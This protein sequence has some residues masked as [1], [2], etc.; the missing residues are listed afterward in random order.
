MTPL[1]EF[2]DK[3]QPESKHSSYLNRYLH[4]FLDVMLGKTQ[5]EFIA[6]G[7]KFCN[8]YSSDNRLAIEARFE[9][10][11]S[12]T[13]D[14]TASS[15]K[16][17]D[18]LTSDQVNIRYQFQSSK[19]KDDRLIS[20]LGKP[21]L[22]QTFVSK[23]ANNFTATI[24]PPIQANRNT[25]ETVHGLGGFQGLKEKNF[26]VCGG[27]RRGWKFLEEW[28]S[29]TKTV[30]VHI[31]LDFT[32]S[33]NGPR[34]E[35]EYSKRACYRINK[36]RNE[37]HL[38]NT[39]TK[40]TQTQ[41]DKMHVNTN[42]AFLNGFKKRTP[43]LLLNYHSPSNG[44]EIL[45]PDC[46]NRQ[47]EYQPS[48][49]PQIARVRCLVVGVDPLKPRTNDFTSVGIETFTI[50]L[51]SSEKRATIR[52]Y[53]RKPEGA[54]LPDAW[55]SICAIPRYG[56]DDLFRVPV[57]ISCS[58]ANDI[59]VAVSFLSNKIKKSFSCT[60]LSVP[61]CH[62]TRKNYEG[63]DTA[64]FPKPRQGNSRGRFWIRTTDLPQL[65]FD[66]AVGSNSEA[67]DCAAPGRLVFQLLRYSR[68]RDARKDVI[69]YCAYLMS[70]K[71]GK[72]GLGLSKNFQQPQECQVRANCAEKSD[73]RKSL[74]C[75]L[76]GRHELSDGC[77][78]LT[79]ETIQPLAHR[80]G[81]AD[82]ADVGN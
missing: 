55:S 26:L 57:D 23:F 42:N 10:L 74:S 38:G 79:G 53:Q 33:F 36:L 37:K 59:R 32:S 67:T 78:C 60:T 39:S 66:N 50:Q 6:H 16:T 51:P 25:P 2:P 45:K 8:V 43:N 72:V 48:T 81:M 40:A 69:Y 13:F 15:N 20:R 44:E 22:G 12:Q 14:L 41:R 64:R 47:I 62:G 30:N 70:P 31:E 28:Y 56:V 9:D 3:Q 73:T 24:F 82:L 65:P 68:Y 27:K 17:V 21:S 35:P 49:Q 7:T 1:R 63:R 80:Y 58:E 75:L 54:A 46:R 11:L 4:N 5:P 71:N 77:R 61:T 76:R 34:S 19:T 18:R 29:T 52:F